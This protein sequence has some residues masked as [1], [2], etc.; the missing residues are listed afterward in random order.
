VLPALINRDVFAL[1]TA[2]V[3]LQMFA[4]W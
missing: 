2:T 3:I 4:F 1:F